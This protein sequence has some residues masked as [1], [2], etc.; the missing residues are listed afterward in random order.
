MKINFKNLFQLK[1]SSAITIILIL[2]SYT[3]LISQSDTFKLINTSWTE[4][5]NGLPLF[6]ITIENNDSKAINFTKVNLR[7]EKI[8]Y[9]DGGPSAPPRST[10][11]SPIAYWD[12]EMPRHKGNFSFKT[13]FPV[14]IEPKEAATIQIRLYVS[15]DKG[16]TYHPLQ[17]FESCS[18]S[19]SIISNNLD[20]VIINELEL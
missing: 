8:W 1:I 12:L 16:R 18:F 20:K 10:E 2:F 11:L 13:V 6:N 15:D 3:D 4:D 19:L 9:Y 5:K 14:R 7:I 17:S